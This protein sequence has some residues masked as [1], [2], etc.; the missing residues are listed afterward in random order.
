M[1][2]WVH[3]TAPPGREPDREAGA[4]ALWQ[5]LNRPLANEPEKLLFRTYT[6]RYGTPSG[7]RLPAL[8]PQVYLHYDPFTPF[9][10]GTLPRQRM[11]FLLLVPNRARIVLEIDGQQHYSTDGRPDPSRYAEMVIEDRRLRLDGYE[12]YRFGG[13][14]FVDQQAASRMVAEFFDR[15]LSRR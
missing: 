8:L 13:Q 9:G 7:D 15:L 11:D 5:R 12:M 4:R 14:E 2:W 3:K 10:L 1:D 6:T